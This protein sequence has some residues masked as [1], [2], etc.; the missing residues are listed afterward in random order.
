M[1]AHIICLWKNL[2]VGRRIALAGAG[3]HSIRLIDLLKKHSLPLPLL[4][5]D[6]KIRTSLSSISVTSP[7]LISQTKVPVDLVV[8]SSDIP[9]T[10][11]ALTASVRKFLPDIQIVDPYDGMPDGPY[12]EE[13]EEDKQQSSILSHE[14]KAELFKLFPNFL[15]YWT[16]REEEKASFYSCSRKDNDI[17]ESELLQAGIPVIHH[18]VDLADFKKWMDAP[19]KSLK[20]YYSVAP[21]ISI[22][23]CLEHY[24]SFKY[25]APEA[26]STIID[27]AACGSPFANILNSL[28]YDAYC[29]DMAYPPGIN[30]KQIGCDAS[31]TGLPEAFASSLILHCAFECFMGDADK[32]FLKE[33]SR[34]MKKG[35]KLCITPLYLSRV[36]INQSSPLCLQDSIIIDQ[37]AKKV[38]R[39]DVWNAPFA[40][41]YSPAIFYSRVYS[42]APTDM[43]VQVVRIDNLEEISCFFGFNIYNRFMLT[44]E[45]KCN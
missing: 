21:Q 41:H 18:K 2:I 12:E 8:I 31:N 40:R 14:N 23:K 36:H 39:S 35:G 15:S 7:E 5:L 6:D 17:I 33:A 3:K 11:Q 4:I 16:G 45:K 38:W 29:L 44:A 1:E 10:R 30:G 32:L 34:I 24:L 20:E 42:G 19:F 22:Q 13:K 9:A 43:N 37:E 27:I 26:G 28:G 25:T